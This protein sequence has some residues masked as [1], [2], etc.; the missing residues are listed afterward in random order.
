MGF[1]TNK[2][3]CGASKHESIE[4]TMADLNKNPNCYMETAT[5]TIIENEV[6]LEI[7]P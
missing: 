2:K 6:L 1:E 4:K 5:S 7:L 3:A